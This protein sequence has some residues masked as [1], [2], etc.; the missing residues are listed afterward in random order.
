M[1]KHWV[2]NFNITVVYQKEAN[3]RFIELVDEGYEPPNMSQYL[4]LG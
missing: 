2:F 4:S 3:G 1:G